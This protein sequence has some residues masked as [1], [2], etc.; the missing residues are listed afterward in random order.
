M[1]TI[2]DKSSWYRSGYAVCPACGA[3]LELESLSAI[4]NC[5]YCGADVKVERS[6]RRVEPDVA[7]FVP[8]EKGDKSKQY[9][10]WNSRQLVNG[11]INSSDPEE[12]LAMA[13]ALDSWR[14]ANSDSAEL[15]STII[16][17]MLV[18]DEELDRALCGLPGKL[19]CSGETDLRRKVIDAG[20][21]YGFKSPGSKGLLFALSLGDA[22]T[23]KLLLEIAEWAVAAG[24]EEYA[25][26]AL[27]GVQTAIGRENE[28]RQICMEI[29]IYRFPC[30]SSF[31]QK[32]FAGFLRNH[33][34]VGYT[35]MHGFVV[36]LIDDCEEEAPHLTP[37]IT[38]AIKK[39]GGAG[40]RLEYLKR[41]E[42]L[43]FA[44]SVAAKNAAL[45]TLRSLPQ[46]LKKED[47]DAALEAIIPMVEKP[48]Y[49][50]SAAETISSFI[51]FGKEMPEQI[52]RLYE[53]KKEKLPSGLVYSIELK[54]NKR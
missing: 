44:K 42:V 22:A 54:L 30:L 46:N 37:M 15:I 49:R 50:D 16:E 39:C 12:K 5:T 34:D 1:K 7:A 43:S 18:S 38:E 36:E 51:W 8:Q 33:F 26:E 40:N 4:K 9:D 29:L 25:Q 21:Y 28:K 10:D 31:T 6:L 45:H 48:E 19:I 23:V 17:I 24:D 27:Y 35:F 14:H 13:T 53:N 11:I 3:P 32:W 41:L 2:K 20:E 52:L 47:V